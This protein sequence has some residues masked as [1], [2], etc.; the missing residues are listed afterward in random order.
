MPAELPRPTILL[1]R[2]DCPTLPHQD[3]PALPAYNPYITVDYMEDVPTS[4]AA[5]VGII[6]PNDPAPTAVADRVSFG[7]NQPYAAH[8]TQR[9]S[10]QPN[11]ALTDQPQHT[12][13]RHNAREAAAPADPATVNQ[14]LAIPFDWL[15]HLDRHV[16]SPMEL[17]H[18]SAFKPHELTQQFVTDT[19]KFNHRAPWYDPSRRL[20]RVF[21][22]LK[23]DD[24]AADMLP[25][26][27]V[28]TLQAFFTPP[29]QPPGL[30]TVRVVVPARMAGL[31]PGGVAWDI[32]VGSTLVVGS[33]AN[34]ENVVVTAVDTATPPKNFTATFYKTHNSGE[35]ITVLT[36]GDRIPGGDR[37]P[38]KVNINT[39]WDPEILHALCDP[40][41]AN[42]FTLTDVNAVFQ[43]LIAS[44]TPNGNPGP[45]DRPFQSLA[46]GFST[47]DTQYPRGLGIEDTVLRSAGDPTDPSRRLFEP[48]LNPAN[49]H[50]YLRSQLLTKLFNHVTTRS[51][52]FAVWVT[53]GFFEVTDDTARPVRLGR[54]IGLAEGRNLRHRFFAVV[55]RSFFAT[56]TS[57]PSASASAVLAT[58][59]TAVPGTVA[60]QP[61]NPNFVRRLGLGDRVTIATPALQEAVIVTAVDATTFTADFQQLHNTGFT[62]SG[63]AV[64]DVVDPV[65]G[66][67][68]QQTI[69][70]SSTSLTPVAAPGTAVI[71]PADPTILPYILP[72]TRLV[73]QSG[74]VSETVTVAGFNPPDWPTEFVASVRFL[75]DTNSQSPTTLSVS[76]VQT[77]ALPR[78]PGTQ[79][80]VQFN[81]HAR[82]E[83]V[84][85]FSVID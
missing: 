84:P 49:A 37:V 33:G 19:G 41:P 39:I 30:S 62:I 54:E 42:S 28:T 40:Q 63:T 83:V 69:T 64:V 10:Q 55:D 46:T 2:L 15:T 6:G 12:F 4:Y 57:L 25:A 48:P 73:I 51:N 31:T 5:T 21:E 65:T 66:L 22:F 50:P 59:I 18:V 70:F 67:V 81:V 1:Q 3:D 61:T 24:R 23:T 52:V 11:P 32:R 16:I 9:R 38:G 53:V 29:G 60:V 80:G 17:L 75:H 13:F 71:Q 20:Y 47:G 85:F 7:R 56:S 43:N 8:V 76:F 14:T 74:G 27:G 68:T 26:V 34:Q 44:R 77:P 78:H 35:P 72:G 82:P 36:E 58:P 79:P 45:N